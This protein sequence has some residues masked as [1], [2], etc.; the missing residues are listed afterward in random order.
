M[1]TLQSQGI[2]IYQCSKVSLYVD[3]IASG[4][5]DFIRVP[6]SDQLFEVM[7]QMMYV[8]QMYLNPTAFNPEAIEALY[9]EGIFTEV[10][11]WYIQSSHT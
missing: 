8:L 5:Y 2:E 11:V 3:R 6:L 4:V 9:I 1:Y 10:P 7:Y